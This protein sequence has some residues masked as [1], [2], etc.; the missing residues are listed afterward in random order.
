MGRLDRVTQRRR[1]ADRLNAPG[2]PPPEGPNGIGWLV[3][4]ATVAGAAHVRSATANQDAFCCRSTPHSRV[5]AVADGHGAPEYV[6]SAT[7][8]RLAADLLADCLAALETA[9]DAAATSAALGDAVVGFIERWR[10]AVRADLS[11]N[12]FTPAN[13]PTPAAAREAVPDSPAPA[14]YGTTALGLWITPQWCGAVAIGDGDLGCVD[15]RGNVRQLCPRPEAIG[16]ETDSLASDNPLQAVRTEVIPSAE[17]TAAW[18]CTDGFSAAQVDPDWRALVGHQLNAMVSA[19]QVGEIAG[20]LPEW[21]APA[22][23]V[24]DDT[25]MALV[26]RTARRGRPG[27]GKQGRKTVRTNEHASSTDRGVRR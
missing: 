9:A 24:G 2:E 18:L 16:V 17:V 11:S 19:G 4:G 1:A 5:A 14:A 6:R 10:A 23:A 15:A 12:P 3:C 8:A 13:R 25:T 7:G 21:L 20:R 22:A 26:V 27:S